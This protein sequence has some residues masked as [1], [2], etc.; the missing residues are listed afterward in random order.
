M[1]VMEEG[2]F[3]LNF[4]RGGTVIAFVPQSI[5]FAISL[6]IV[7][8]IINIWEGMSCTSMFQT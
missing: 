3:L 8:L 6:Q 2:I 4:M 5:F 1:I 7:C